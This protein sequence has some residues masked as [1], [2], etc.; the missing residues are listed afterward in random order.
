MSINIQGRGKECERERKGERKR[1]TIQATARKTQLRIE[2]LLRINL[3]KYVEEKIK[4]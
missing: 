3:T 2:F 1:E 4:N